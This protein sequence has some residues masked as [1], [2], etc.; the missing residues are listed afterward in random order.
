MSGQHKRGEHAPTEKGETQNKFRDYGEIYT[1]KTKKNKK[2]LEIR[3]KGCNFVAVNKKQ[4]NMKTLTLRIY[5]NEIDAA[6][7]AF[8]RKSFSIYEESEKVLTVE[9]SKEDIL[10]LYDCYLLDDTQFKAAYPEYMTYTERV[11][12]TDK[13]CESIK[14]Y[15]RKTLCEIIENGEETEEFR[16]LRKLYLNEL[17]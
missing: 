11:A 10:K 14:V 5:K 12:Y 13:M 8:I 16:R 4:S 9:G 3:E 2:N 15:F 6:R 1:Q 7:L 17:R